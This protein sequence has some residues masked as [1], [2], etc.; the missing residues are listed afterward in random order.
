M[1]VEMSLPRPERTLRNWSA[2]LQACTAISFWGCNKN[3]AWCRICVSTCNSVE[4]PAIACKAVLVVCQ[5]LLKQMK[6]QLFASK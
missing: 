5:Q 6:A 1:E 4:P 2:L 3:K